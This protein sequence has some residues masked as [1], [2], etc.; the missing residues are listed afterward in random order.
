ML[1][2]RKTKNKIDLS[3]AL[4]PRTQETHAAV[5]SYAKRPPRREVSR[6]DERTHAWC[7]CEVHYPT[8]ERKSGVLLDRSISGLRMRFRTRGALPDRFKVIAPRIG[9]TVLVK[10]VWQ[11]GFD[12]GC[13]ILQ[14]IQHRPTHKS[15]R[16]EKPSGSDHAAQFSA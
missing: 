8:G 6:R 13:E 4:T 9:L 14:Q 3:R 7:V 1:G 15:F 16:A 11:D 12:A 2:R 10:V 5:Q